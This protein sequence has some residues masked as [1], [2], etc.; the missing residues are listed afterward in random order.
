MLVDISLALAIAAAG[1]ASLSTIQRTSETEA[2]LLRQQVR[3]RWNVEVRHHSPLPQLQY[4]AWINA[5][6][7]R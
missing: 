7:H 5:L 2:A 6:H 1:I 4:D 3:D